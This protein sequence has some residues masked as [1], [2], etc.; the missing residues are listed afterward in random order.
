MYPEAIRSYLRSKKIK[1]NDQI[2][3]LKW[4]TGAWPGYLEI[5]T[6]SGKIVGGKNPYF[7][8]DNAYVWFKK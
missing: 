2:K 6:K 7:E 8:D 3:S 1:D 5:K 4:R